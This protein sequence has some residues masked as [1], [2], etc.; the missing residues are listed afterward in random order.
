MATKR[1]E[2]RKAAIASTNST[3]D[4]HHHLSIGIIAN[5]TNDTFCQWTICSRRSD[6]AEMMHLTKRHCANTEPTTNDFTRILSLAHIHSPSTDVPC[7]FHAKLKTSDSD[8]NRDNRICRRYEVDRLAVFE[9]GYKSAVHEIRSNPVT[10]VC[11]KTHVFEESCRH[12]HT[13]THDA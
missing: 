7:I 6:L 3:K 5:V 11:I 8:F 2:T 10:H 4:E 1:K 12:T 13:H 9:S